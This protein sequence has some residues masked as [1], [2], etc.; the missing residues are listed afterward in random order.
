MSRVLELVNAA[1]GAVDANEK[2]S[3]LHRL[4]EVLLECTPLPSVQEYK[5][6][7]DGIVAMATER[8][9][10][11]AKTILL[12][13]EDALE[14]NRNSQI[15]LTPILAQTR[16]ALLEAIG[17]IL[18][19]NAGP[20]AIRKA[21]KLLD[22]YLTSIVYHIWIEPLDP[23]DEN[24]WHKLLELIHILEQMIEQLQDAEAVLLATRV[25]ETSA[26]H[27]S[28]A[29]DSIHR[30]PARS[31]I[32]PDALHLGSI[33]PAHRFA[34]PDQLAGFGTNIIYALTN[35]LTNA[36]RHPMLAFGRREYVTLIHSLSLLSCL[37]TEYAAIVVPCFL[38]LHA[39]VET[40]DPRIQDTIVLN[41]K[42]NLIKLLR[43]PLPTPLPNDITTAL[44]A[45]DASTRAFEAIS[46]SKEKRRT[47][48]AAP[49][50]ASLK[51]FKRD[52]AKR[53][54]QF[55]AS[56]AKRFKR[57]VQAEK[58]VAITT[59]SLV[60]LPSDQV[61][62]F[63]LVNMANL[64]SVVPLNAKGEKLELLHTPSALKDR[65]T[66][67]L[68]TLATP[69]SVLA[70]AMNAK[71]TAAQRRDP[72]RRN[73]VATDAP[74]LLHIF[75]ENSLDNVTN[76][77]CANAQTLVEP[78]ISVTKDEV[79]REYNAIRVNIKPVTDEWC[80][81]MA[82][83]TISR[84]LENEYGILTSGHEKLR[85][86]LVCRLATSRWLLEE[87]ARDS[88]SVH[89]QIVDFVGEQLH[90]RY[91]ILVSLVYHEYTRTLYDTMATTSNASYPRYTGL[92]KLI[93]SMLQA[94]LDP[95]IASDKKLYY[96]LL[97]HIPRLTE[98]VL[99]MMVA[100]LVDATD[101][102][103]LVMGVSAIRNYIMDRSTGQEACLNILLHFATHVEEAI[104]NLTI[105]CLANQ[106][107]PLPKMHGL[108]E[109]H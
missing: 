61:V 71:K 106:I 46:K 52:D 78:I 68:S 8:N 83:L 2:V 35:R 10:N 67:I 94:R 28:F 41:M 16:F 12:L 95:N 30:D 25:L 56:T 33:P 36:P 11:V 82:L 17:I 86:A 84:M 45:M 79:T 104:R 38:N 5:L 99:K 102:Q 32:Q 62:D 98:D 107:Y 65:I 22:K 73:N 74:S 80:R 90:K 51:N 1:N 96:S 63:V 101:N 53:T 109:A 24:I 19:I 3:I 70:L 23:L 97:S 66:S 105:R 6:A 57:E 9:V 21:M 39:S 20:S 77:V 75:D 37:R 108:I 15:K 50:D 42:A 40:L 14:P 60:N 43:L 29:R 92:L 13:I 31:N 69:S 49:S 7:M 58:P 48:G 47:Y 100:Q 18:T 87:K 85:E 91:M 26:F 72:R 93:C 44:I 59:E 103:R 76:I 34:R 64:P 55:E 4:K 89:R 27:L 81:Q 54:M 88:K